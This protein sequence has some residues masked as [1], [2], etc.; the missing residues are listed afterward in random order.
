MI[1]KD[2]SSIIFYFICMIGMV[3]FGIMEIR[4][5]RKSNNPDYTEGIMTIIIGLTPVCMLI[6]AGLLIIGIIY[7]IIEIPNKIL[8]KIL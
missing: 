5:E 2:L 4:E 1:D 3:S 6:G 7:C 8:K